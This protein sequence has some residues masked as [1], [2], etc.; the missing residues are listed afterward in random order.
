MALIKVKTGGVDNTTNLGRRNLI[1]NGAMQVA[2]RG[3]SQTFTGVGNH[4][5]VDRFFKGYGSS[6]APDI[7]MSQETD[8]PAGFTNSL[9][10]YVNSVTT[11]ASNHNMVFAQRIEGYNVTQ[12]AYGT[13]DAK[14]V[15]LSFWVK[16]N[17]TGTRGVWMMAK[18]TS[19]REYMASYTINTANTW[20]YKTVTIPP[21]TITTPAGTTS[22]SIL[23]TWPLSTGSD[24]LVSAST[25]WVAENA[26][27]GLSGEPDLCDTVGNYWQITGVQLEVGD[28][29][30]PFE[31]RS[32][33]EELALC[34]RYYEFF[35]N[36][37]VTAQGTWLDVNNA[38]AAIQVPS[39]VPMRT[40][41]TVIGTL[42]NRY[43][44]GGS[45]WNDMAA[46]GG[47]V[48]PKGKSDGTGRVMNIVINSGTYT[49][50][51]KG[52]VRCSSTFA[53][54]AEL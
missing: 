2:Q 22:E 24:D 37:D 53:Y 11:P 40:L 26:Y 38:Y 43:G 27:R 5:L 17:Q 21:N 13:S 48:L 6:Y 36:Y 49:W 4:F 9:K 3:T 54:D 1:I 10:M 29:A 23:L 12:L 46:G 41:P 35:G 19:D 7:T 28:T 25:S 8:A 31:H 16:S 47:S 33:G 51:S 42:E 30:T 50:S 14:N 32:F 20:E 34:Q 39:S 52:W 45:T 18:G 44:A 15:T